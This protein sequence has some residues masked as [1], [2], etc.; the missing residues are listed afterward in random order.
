VASIEFS[1]VNAPL[2]N[3]KERI[4]ENKNLKTVTRTGGNEIT[5][6]ERE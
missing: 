3:N 4:E 1:T 5:K 6:G 2:D